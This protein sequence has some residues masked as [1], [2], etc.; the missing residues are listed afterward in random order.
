MQGSWR[1]SWGL[2][3]EEV[4]PPTCSNPP[5]VPNELGS[6]VC[7]APSADILFWRGR[8]GLFLAQCFMVPSIKAPYQGNLS[9]QRK[10]RAMGVLFS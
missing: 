2:L 7:A 6:F 9:R 5:E 1:R 10:Q 8:K 3:G 4:A